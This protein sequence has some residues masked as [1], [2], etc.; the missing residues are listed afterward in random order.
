MNNMCWKQQ[1]PLKNTIINHE[2]NKH[3]A[4]L[5]SIQ[6]FHLQYDC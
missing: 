1:I 2:L 4:Q 6:F 3:Q 5:L